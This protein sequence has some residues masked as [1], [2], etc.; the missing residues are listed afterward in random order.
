MTQKEIEAIVRDYV[1]ETWGG[2]AEDHYNEYAGELAASFLEWLSERYEIVAK[3]A[4]LQSDAFAKEKAS[5][6]SYYDN[7]KVIDV[8]CRY[9]NPM[10]RTCAIWFDA[11]RPPRECK[12]A[13]GF[14]Q[15]KCNHFTLK[16]E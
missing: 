7:R 9:F 4:H 10:S 3:Q 13:D 15:N 2:S 12:Y 11:H 1:T 5:K 8:R 16:P 6:E 14:Q